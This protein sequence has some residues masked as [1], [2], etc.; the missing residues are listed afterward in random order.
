VK[1]LNLHYDIYINVLETLAA[2]PNQKPDLIAEA[3]SLCKTLKSLETGIMTVFWHTIL[4][5]TN[6]TSKLLQSETIDLSVAV[7]LLKS[8]A[9][10]VEQQRNN[11]NLFCDTAASLCDIADFKETRQR[12]PKKF[13]DDSEELA[14]IF[15]AKDDFRVNTFICIIDLL[16][17]D[18][19]RRIGAYETIES[20]FH[21]LTTS[22]SSDESDPSISK[23]LEM[24]PTD[25]N[26]DL[27][28]EW[29]QW[30]CFLTSF[31][32]T[33]CDR[34]SPLEML[35]IMVENDLQ[36]GFPN[37]FVALRIYF[38]LP[39]S[40]ACA[41]RSFSHMGRVKSALRSTM[42]QQRLSHLAI[43]NI[44]NDIVAQL[45]FDNL[46]NTFASTKSR[47]RNI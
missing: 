28:D 21:F 17:T 10:Y 29:L 9:D 19:R 30:R 12:R 44:E 27:R 34:S 46:I 26:S 23:I 25:L 47:K 1:S 2:D 8:L 15:S 3:K 36:S 13:C 31:L 6:K 32:P 37:V 18:L 45:D 4:K 16:G 43:L 41:E 38:T 35:N 5:R 40:N 39:I 11:F 22:Q 24:Y 7:S 33:L 42:G 14:T 20:C